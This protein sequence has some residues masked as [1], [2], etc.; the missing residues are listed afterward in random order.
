MRSG[1]G[2]DKRAGFTLI[3]LLVVLAIMGLLLTITVPNYIQREMRAR[4]AVL[5]QNLAVMR[6]A[7]DKH[8][9]DS[10]RY[11]K[12]P[13]ELVTK[14]YLRSLPSD[15]MT[16]SDRTWIVVPPEDPQLGGVYDLRSGA[17]GT[18]SD[19]QPYAQW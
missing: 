9:A 14:R 12:T 1:N 6:D 13:Q 8:F 15:P 2:G 7:L 18:G 17:R 16:H 11:P 10:G 3:E 19:G 4:E 5:R